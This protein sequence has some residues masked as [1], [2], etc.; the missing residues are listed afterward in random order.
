VDRQDADQGGQEEGLLVGLQGEVL[1]SRDAQVV[2]HDN[3]DDREVVLASALLEDRYRLVVHL[4]GDLLL[5][6]LDLVHLAFEPYSNS[7]STLDDPPSE[8]PRA[9][10]LQ[11]C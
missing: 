7:S 5:V 9:L 11:L 2:G 6:D 10:R 8:L 3:L 4:V 1:C